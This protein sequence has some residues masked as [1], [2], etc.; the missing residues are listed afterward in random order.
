MAVWFGAIADY[1]VALTPS[2]A[3]GA[4]AGAHDALVRNKLTGEVDTVRNVELVKIGNTV[5]TVPAGQAQP[6]DGVYGELAGYVQLAG[7]SGTAGVAFHAD[8]IV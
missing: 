3:Q 7:V 5:Y 1:Q 8:W 4:A 6:A 2:T